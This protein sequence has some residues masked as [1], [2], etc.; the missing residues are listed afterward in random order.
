MNI[1]KFNINFFDETI[2]SNE[3]YD[4]TFIFINKN[5]PISLNIENN[6]KYNFENKFI[7]N[8]IF[9]DSIEKKDEVVNPVVLHDMNGNDENEKTKK[10]YNETVNNFDYYVS[11]PEIKE[12][13]ELQDDYNTLLSSILIMNYE[14]YKNN[15][16]VELFYEMKK[17]KINEKILYLTILISHVITSLLDSTIKEFLIKKGI[18][19]INEEKEEKIKHYNETFGKN[20][21]ET[22]FTEL[23]KSKGINIIGGSNANKSNKLLNK[24]VN[25]YLIQKG[26]NIYSSSFINLDASIYQNHVNINED[27][28][29]ENENN[30]LPLTHKNTDIKNKVN[31]VELFKH[32]VLEDKNLHYLNKYLELEPDEEV[33][34]FTLESKLREVFN[35]FNNNIINWNFIVKDPYIEEYNRLIDSINLLKILLSEYEKEYD[36]TNIQVIH[37]YNKNKDFPLKIDSIIIFIK[38]IIQQIKK[39]TSYFEN[40]HD[41]NKKID[42]FNFIFDI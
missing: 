39:D 3:K 19:K 26:D 9:L 24:L 1:E 35:I 32:N 41:E 2:E 23:I 17:I 36:I 34:Y 20:D 12:L 8:N 14:I 30:Y 28:N 33:N 7:D 42:I 10:Y 21:K 18:L 27:Y 22:I 29:I 38:K 6:K 25:K 15:A 31:A 37:Y 13:H 5:K 40:K 16:L 4:K 11:P